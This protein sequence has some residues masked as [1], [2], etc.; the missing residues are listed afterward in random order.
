MLTSPRARSPLALRLAE[1]SLTLG[2]TFEFLSGLYFRG[3]LK[4]ASA[5]GRSSDGTPPVLIITPTLGLKPPSM[6]MSLALLHEFASLDLAHAGARYRE[7]L[8]ADARA[9][10]GSLDSTARVVLLGSIATAKYFEPLAEALGSQLCYPAAFVGRGDMSRGG[11]LL[12]SVDEGREL[13]YVP[14]EAGLSR[15]GARPPRL[16]PL[17]RP[18]RPR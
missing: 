6:P 3:K 14:L 8:A 2:E 11:L 5:F 15:R 17:P 10:A 16:P 12:R 18:P 4:Y 7:P 13:D 9:L 1:G